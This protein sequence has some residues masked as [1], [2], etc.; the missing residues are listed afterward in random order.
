MKNI[1]LLN[2]DFVIHCRNLKYFKD[3]Y[4]V[5][6]RQGIVRS[7]VYGMLHRPTLLTYE[8]IKVGMSSPTLK[9]REHQVGERLV[10]QVSWLPGWEG[11]R[12]HTSNGLDFWNNIQ[13]DLIANGKLKSNFNKNNIEI[14]VWDVS[15]RMATADMLLEHEIKATGWAE[16]ELAYQH[17]QMYNTLPPLNYADPSKTS[18]YLRG[19]VSKQMF[20]QLFEVTT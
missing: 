11:E 7:Y 19:Y 16:G 17:K 2:P 10:R 4:E 8:F 12:P 1:K 9:D 5:M 15:K 18:A 3:I 13:L 6:R 14:A 20:E